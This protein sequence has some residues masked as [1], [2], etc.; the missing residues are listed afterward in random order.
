MS[1]RFNWTPD[2][3][4]I[5]NER[6]KLHLL[7]GEPEA[8]LDDLNRAL[9]LNPGIA[10]FQ[11]RRAFINRQLQRNEAAIV[12]A[13]QA[14]VLSPTNLWAYETMLH[15]YR[16]SHQDSDF[17]QA[18]EELRLAA[19]SWVDN[20]ARARAH[21]TLLNSYHLAGRTQEFE[22][23]IETSLAAAKIWADLA[24]RNRLYRGLASVYVR[25][26]ENHR[27]LD[28][29]TWAVEA[30]PDDVGSRQLRIEA[31]MALNDDTGV[32]ADCDAMAAIDLS[33]P[34][35]LRRRARQMGWGLP[36]LGAIPGTDGCGDPGVPE[37]V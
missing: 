26:G 19:E 37:L 29:A 18:A 22:R 20:D 8:A 5:Y 4:V 35:P 17:N 32:E 14:L 36:A 34:E 3:P 28:A 12:D 30:R 6:A 25:A 10:N 21:L 11:A 1:E 7:R 16:T 27:A 2:D 33:E 9:E 31:L 23:T 24:A 15:I 13:R